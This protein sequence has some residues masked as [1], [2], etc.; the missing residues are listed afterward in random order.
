MIK[1]LLNKISYRIAATILLVIFLTLVIFGI[2]YIGNYSKRINQRIIS[3]LEIPS[4]LINNNLL[5]YEA[6][7]QSNLISQLTDLKITQCFIIGLNKKVYYTSDPLMACLNI[8]KFPEFNGYFQNLNMGSGTPVK[9]IIIE[10]REFSILISPV[11]LEK[12]KLLGYLFIKADISR[13]E[14]AKYNILILYILGLIICSIL[15][16]III[17]FIINKNLIYRI[18]SISIFLDKLKSGQLIQQVEDILNNDELS[19]VEKDMGILI[20]SLNQKA[21]FAKEIEKKNFNY[22]YNAS[23]EYDE[24]GIALINMR[25]SLYK[26]AIDEE[27]RRLEDSHR[28]WATQGQAKFGDILRQHYDS[29]QE[30]AYTIIKE[31]ISY[32]EANQA[33]LFL[34]NDDD[35]KNIYLELSASYAFDRRK[36]IAK[37]IAVG[38]GLVGSCAFEKQTINLTEIPESYI[39]IT[40][41]L[42][43]SNPKALLIVPLMREQEVLGVIEIAS[44]N[45]FESY[46]I[47]FLEKLGESIASTLFNVKINTQTAYLLSQSQE[48]TEE[49]RA[50]EEEMRQNMEELHATQEE[51]SRKQEE[52]LDKIEELEKE[53]ERKNKEIDKHRSHD[54]I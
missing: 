11:F 7:N 33:S 30:L 37:K 4:R 20:E 49:M 32:L 2:I 22:K 53:M 54:Q 44:F 40:S 9:D 16:S 28:N 45:K 3:Q 8:S 35:K 47:E 48:Q 27:N 51:M 46:Q 36:Y 42:G 29:I 10:N 21:Q 19:I 50:Q 38:E 5:S 14:R 34:L 24:L 31:T 52:L 18:K 43:R 15:C 39:E 13:Y 12:T 23:G 41:G 25:D 1:N 6:V 26:A 17:I